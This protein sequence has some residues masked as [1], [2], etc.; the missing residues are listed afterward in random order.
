MA[1]PPTS[2]NLFL[3]ILRAHHA[4]IL[5]KAA[6]QKD[7]PQLDL[8]EFGWEINDGVPVPAIAKG[9]QDLSS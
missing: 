4:V 7:P 9:L 6:D 5:G 2:A 3:H 1:L 8:T